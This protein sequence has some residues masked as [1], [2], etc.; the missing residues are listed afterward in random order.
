MALLL[1]RLGLLSRGF[2]GTEVTA[3]TNIMLSAT[4]VSEDAQ[5]GSIVG[6][7]SSD[8]TDPV[9]YE[10]VTLTGTVTLS[11]TSVSENAQPGSIVAT[12]SSDLADAT[13]TLV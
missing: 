5:P 10:L 8:G 7:I 13:F 6:I 2:D 1:H 11:T 4:S 3:P 12:I 9:T